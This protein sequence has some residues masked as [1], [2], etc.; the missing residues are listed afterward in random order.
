MSENA[1][2]AESVR[3]NLSDIYSGLQDSQIEK[4]L[5]DI[6]I[7]SK[8][9][10]NEFRG[11]LD[12]KLGDSIELLDKIQKLENK[13][14]IYL[15]LLQA[16]DVSNQEIK[17][18]ESKISE[19]LS[20]ASADHMAFFNIELGKIESVQ[21]EKLLQA[22]KRVEF[23]KP[24]LVN[25]REKAKHLLSEE[26]ERAL[27]LRQAYGPAELC[28]FFQERLSEARF[29]LDGNDKPVSM[30]TILNTIADN[31]NREAR[32]K[33]A[34]SLNN[35]LK[36]EIVPLAVQ[37]LNAVIGLKNIE[38]VERKYPSAMAARNQSNQVDEEVVRALH[39]AVSTKGAELA[40]RY[41][42]LLGKKLKVDKLY[43][44]DRNARII[45]S[46]ETV[47]WDDGVKLVHE[48]FD[49]FSPTLADLFIKMVKAGHIDAPHYAGKTTGAFN[50]SGVMPEPLGART[51]TL[52]NYFG[53]PGDVQTL[54]HE[55]GHAVHG[56]L[57][58]QAQ[59]SLMQSAPIA[60]CETASIF[61]EMVTFNFLL[62][63]ITTPEQK[64]ALLMEKS[65]DF[66][67]TVVRQ[68]SFSEFEQRIHEERK[69][70]KISTEK[71]TQHWMA[72]TKHFY[73]ADG[74]IF[75]YKNMD[76]LWSYVTHFTSP[77]YVYGY[78]F[79]EVLT[80]S[81]Y[82]VKDKFGKDFEPLYLDLLRAGGTKDA[83][84][85]VA[86]FGLNPNDPNFWID[87]MKASVEKWIEEAESLS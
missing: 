82:A 11:K 21:F 28:E 61:A 13:I 77:F 62:K 59:G 12:A 52:L 68:I 6:E 80:Q 57:A 54:A 87:G 53:T 34:E 47:L 45:H 75:E 2:G 58:G 23:H 14:G 5:Q 37:T 31:P 44:S 1:F 10:D 27:T 40:Q 85:L 22:D 74:D 65:N 17:K 33:A 19:R 49:S 43:W 9:F 32:L 46:D 51:F 50:I 3:F 71:F 41:Y 56:L 26:V 15:M 24:M 76:N 29:P 69:G 73:G 4:D 55:S 42:R 8:R 48:A 25:I 78:A 64:L 35:G 18:L 83:T 86:P 39:D 81:L 7:L 84:S 20:R 70:G 60:Y 67:N 30:E 36:P 72:V 79:G 63:K 16:C 38:N 66:F